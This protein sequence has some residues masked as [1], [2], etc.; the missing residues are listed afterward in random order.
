MRALRWTFRMA[1]MGVMLGWMVL[2]FLPIVT[3]LILGKL[4]G[5]KHPP[6]LPA[7]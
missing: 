4:F 5:T 7:P 2:L 3:L 6:R 1:G